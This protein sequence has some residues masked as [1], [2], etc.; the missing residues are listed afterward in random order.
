MLQIFRVKEIFQSI[1]L[2]HILA[3]YLSTKCGDNMDI[4]IL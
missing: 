1:S 3:L 2:L 4:Q